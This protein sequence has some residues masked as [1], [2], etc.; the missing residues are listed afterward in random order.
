MHERQAW[1]IARAARHLSARAMG[2]SALVVGLACSSSKVASDGPSPSSS[3]GSGRTGT[4]GRGASVGGGGVASTAGG[5][6]SGGITTSGGTA[7]SGGTTT[8]GGLAGAS[9]QAG[10][11]GD[12]AAAGNAA[13]GALGTAGAG[14]TAG[15]LGTAGSAP[16]GWTFDDGPGPFDAYAVQPSTLGGLT[17]FSRLNGHPPGCMDATLGFMGAGQEMRVA[18]Q[19]DPPLDLSGKT[20]SAEVWER[21][22]WNDPN[23]PGQIKLYLLSGASGNV[24]AE[25]PAVDILLQVWNVITFDLSAPIRTT[26]AFDASHVHELGI[27]FLSPAA[28]PNLTLDALIDN[29]AINPKTP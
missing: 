5:A 23:Y 8:S 6:A 24:Y 10:R 2:L 17:A 21:S 28:Y 7:T 1:S 14:G 13:G 15:T 16:T 9:A 25:G 27:V 20:I 12:G 29:I 4:G 11:S 18:A 19:F 3:G 26:G 22:G